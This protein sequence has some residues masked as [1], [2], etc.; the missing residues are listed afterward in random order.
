MAA[1]V[2]TLAQAA[3]DGHLSAEPM[4]PNTM[5]GIEKIV[6]GINL[7]LERI[8]VPADE[9]SVGSTFTHRFE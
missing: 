2:N 8:A 6:E 4:P 9:G 5:A 7:L 3:A 1:D